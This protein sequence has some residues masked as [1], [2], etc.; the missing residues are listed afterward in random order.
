MEVTRSFKIV[1]IILTFIWAFMMISNYDG[2]S[3]PEQAEVMR[4]GLI[5]QL[6]AEADKN[7]DNQ[8]VQAAIDGYITS[9]EQTL[10]TPNYKKHSL[11]RMIGCF[12]AFVG[13]VFL[14]NGKAI[15]LHMLG[16]AVLFLLFTGFYAI[17]FGLIGWVFNLFYIF[18]GGLSFLF[19]YQKRAI[20]N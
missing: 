11:Y 5:A 1:S 10:L 19:F 15:G 6:Q 20:L 2:Y 12:I 16:A 7:D 14:R 8:E 9:I 17:G 18:F 3:N 13:V 4:T